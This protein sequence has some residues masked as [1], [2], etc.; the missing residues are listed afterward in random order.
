SDYVKDIAAVFSVAESYIDNRVSAV[1]NPAVV[2]DIDETSLSNWT[3]ID[4]DHF[5]F[6]KSGACSERRG[7]SCV[8]ASWIAKGRATAIEPA[9]KFFDSARCGTGNL[10]ARSN[11]SNRRVRGR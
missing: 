10:A 7:F 2:L 1:K 8:F 3:N 4:L 5:G 6:I 11:A 9:R